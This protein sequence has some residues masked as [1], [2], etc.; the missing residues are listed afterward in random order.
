MINI[1]HLL[2]ISK[3]SKE[4]CIEKPLSNEGDRNDI[5]LIYIS[6]NTPN[7]HNVVGG[8]GPFFLIDRRK[9]NITHLWLLIGHTVDLMLRYIYLQK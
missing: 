1:E 3:I 8:A 6:G 7:Y 5:L 9:G 4:T 2:S